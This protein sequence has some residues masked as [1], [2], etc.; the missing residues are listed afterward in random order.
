MDTDLAISIGS[1]FIA[2]A[3]AIFVP[4]F[5]EWKRRPVF[6][7]AVGHQPFGPGPEKFKFLHIKV[8][9]KPLKNRFLLRNTAT[10]CKVSMTFDELGYENQ[11]VKEE[12]ARWSAAPEPVSVVATGPGVDLVYDS[13]K[14]PFSYKLDVSPDNSGEFLGIVV[15]YEGRESAF[16]FNSDSYI[17]APGFDR[18]C[19]PK[20]ELPGEE[21]RVT[22][23]VA[24]GGVEDSG[25]FRL[26][27]RG[28]SLEDFKLEPWE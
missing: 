6:S 17:P 4:L 20:F 11:P 13:T 16:A 2:I 26:R 15:K 1:A 18:F 3:V 19:I 5:I 8:I 23:N 21:Y 10:G 25:I 22:I 9:N 12:P 14:V 7:L 24:S 27:N 28:T